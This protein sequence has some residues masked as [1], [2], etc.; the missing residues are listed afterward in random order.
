M[1]VF[2]CLSAL[3]SLSLFAMLLSLLYRT[4]TIHMIVIVNLITLLCMLPV[5]NCNLVSIRLFSLL[6]RCAW[7][8][9][10]MDLAGIGVD[11]RGHLED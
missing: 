2:D 8:E 7:L 3:F 11:D 4:A 10:R 9:L 5:D 6:G 1:E